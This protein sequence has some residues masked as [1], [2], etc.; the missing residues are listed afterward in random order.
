MADGEFD[1]SL[2]SWKVWW[3]RETVQ[4][5]A[6]G[7]K[8]CV[9]VKKL[10]GQGLLLP[11]K[12]VWSSRSLEDLHVNGEGLLTSY[13]KDRQPSGYLLGD[14]LLKLNRLWGDALPGPV[15]VNPL[16]ERARRELALAQGCQL[17]K[18]LSFV[19][20]SA[21]KA[22]RGRRESTTYLKSLA[23]QRLAMKA[24]KGKQ[25][26]PTASTTASASDPAPSPSSS[27][28]T[29]PLECSIHI[30]LFYNV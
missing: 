16:K 2:A 21:L 27:T 6:E 22:D 20:T 19:R 12:D 29:M 23:N 24:C 7:L 11:K 9:D 14:A 10:P 28:P 25:T 30:Y 8:Y 13:P 3:N 1:A 17:K 4:D 5:I 26:S 15:D 18:L